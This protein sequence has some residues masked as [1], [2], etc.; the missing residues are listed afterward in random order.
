MRTEVRTTVLSM[1]TAGL[2]YRC[3][4]RP[5]KPALLDETRAPH[6]A[7]RYLA[8]VGGFA[9]VHRLRTSVDLA[10][11]ARQHAFRPDLPEFLA[12]VR[13]QPLHASCQRTGLTTWRYSQ[14]RIS[15]GPA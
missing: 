14:S 8:Q 11:Q 3:H 12:A 15:S 13:D 6:I 2:H 5:R 4:T 7:Q 9:N 10:Q 1:Q